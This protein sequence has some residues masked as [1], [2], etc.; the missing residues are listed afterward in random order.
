LCQTSVAFVPF[1]L[2]T[3]IVPL[4]SILGHS[5]IR[6]ELK[7]RGIGVATGEHVHNRVVFKQLL[8][9]DAIDVVQIDSCHLAGVSE[10]LAVL[11]MASKFGQPDAR[12]PVVWDCASMPFT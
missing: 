12:T 6:R 2:P 3:V 7:P 10:V 1:F 4:S 5:C 9:V 8:Q 11:H